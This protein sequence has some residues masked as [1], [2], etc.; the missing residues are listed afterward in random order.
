MTD[1]FGAHEKFR[2]KDVRRLF[3]FIQELTST[4]LEVCTCLE[5]VMRGT[6]VVHNSVLRSCQ[7]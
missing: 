2:G 3:E 5:Q 1:Y 4:E 7:I 6:M